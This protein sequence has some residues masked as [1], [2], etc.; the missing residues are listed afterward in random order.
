MVSSYSDVVSR[1]EIIKDLKLQGNAFILYFDPVGIR[2]NGFQWD[3]VLEN[4][5]PCS[6]ENGL[7]TKRM[8]SA[9]ETNEIICLYLIFLMFFD[10]HEVCS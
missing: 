10:Y 2:S 4:Q 5:S 1:G 7:R 3:H 9:Y 8:K 6:V